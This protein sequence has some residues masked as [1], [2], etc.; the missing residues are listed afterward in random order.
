M[1][2]KMWRNQNPASRN[3][4]GATCMEHSMEV[5]KKTK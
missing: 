4:N 2:V 3:V 5:L 1:L